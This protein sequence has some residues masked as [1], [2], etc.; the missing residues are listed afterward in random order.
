VPVKYFWREGYGRIS[1][2]TRVLELAADI[3]EASLG[4]ALAP[5]RL[6]LLGSNMHI[7]GV[8]L[9]TSNEEDSRGESSDTVW[10]Y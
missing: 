9:D 3:R 2:G 5:R 1:D 7:K 10:W 4:R 6:A 8:E